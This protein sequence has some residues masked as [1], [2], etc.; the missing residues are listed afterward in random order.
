[1]LSDARARKINAGDKPI[2]DTS[3]RGLY[4]FPSSAS[5]TGKWVL[6]Y[7]SPETGKRRDMGLGIYPLVPIRDV[8]AKAFALRQQI[9]D[10]VDP[11]EQR[12][13]EQEALTKEAEIPTFEAAAR[14]FHTDHAA[15]FRNAKHKDQWINT[16]A[17]EVFPR[18]GRARVDQL[19]AADFADC[20][21]PIWLSKAETASRVRQRCDAVMKWCA[22][23]G[24]IVASPVSVVD[25]LLPKQ[26]GKRERVEH[27]PAMP[28][29]LVPGFVRNHL[30]HGKPTVSRLM[31]ELVILTAVRSGE[32]RLMSWDELDFRAAIWTIP[33]NRMKAK[34]AHRVPLT[35]HCL[36]LLKDLRKV[37][38]ARILAGAAP[39]KLVFRT[40]KGTAFSDMVLTTY[41]RN[42]KAESDIPGRIA[43]AHGFRSSFRDWAS[44]HGYPRDLAERALVHTI[45]NA[46]EAAYHRTD[47]LDQRRT[48]MEDWERFVLGMRQRVQK[49]V[50][51]RHA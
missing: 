26:P 48:M 47:L 22:A 14:A 37:E 10:G 25:K 12:R 42:Q 21:R 9:E 16:L 17:A 49:P 40:R 27:Q 18:I 50:P 46:T 44:E 31:L 19:T 20:L 51:K 35:P 28:W 30:H 36:A 6:R 2:S 38:D 7:K 43:T 24:F 15:G 5:G 23:R 3:V 11:L 39:S 8:R 1:M 13:R 34:Q 41:L 45:R 4:L 29:R 32:L 33:A